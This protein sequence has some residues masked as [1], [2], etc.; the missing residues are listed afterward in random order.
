[1][2]LRSLIHEIQHTS[3]SKGNMALKNKLA[4]THDF[5][6]CSITQTIFLNE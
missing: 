6:Y 2:V 4:G 5:F 3:G 1:M